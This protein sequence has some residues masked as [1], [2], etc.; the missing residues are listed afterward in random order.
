MEP[1]AAQIE[2]AAQMGPS[3]AVPS[4]AP[5]IIAR[6]C[7]RTAVGFRFADSRPRVGAGATARNERH[8]APGTIR[9][10]AQ[11]PGGTTASALGRGGHPTT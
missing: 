4:I 6:H 7:R 10:K 11:K 5:R 2:A 9:R 8:A 3:I 1:V